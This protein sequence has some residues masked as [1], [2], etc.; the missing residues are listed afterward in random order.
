LHENEGYH[1][2]RFLWRM[3]IELKEP[4]PAPDWP[5]GFVLRGFT[6]GQD[7]RQVFDAFED[8]FRDHWG[9]T[10]WDYDWWKRRIYGQEDFDPGLW[11][12]A[13]AG[14]HLAGG[15]LCSYKQDS[16]WVNQL[17]VRRPWRRQG[18]GLALLYQ[19]FGEFYRRGTRL[20]GLGV[21]AQSPTG[22]TRLYQR[23]GMS[24]AHEFIS[25][26]KEIRP[27]FNLEPP[28]SQA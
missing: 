16:G 11:L 27:G 9:Y 24:V 22:A 8:A 15:V 13:S 5:A 1:P 6:R 19:A 4:P 2:A 7:D 17:A 3:R 25:Y 26:E 14:D 28:G 18:L 20:I 21:D 12:L 23:A 10:P